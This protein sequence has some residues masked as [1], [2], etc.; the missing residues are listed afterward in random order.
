MHC[1]QTP[2]WGSARVAAR[3]WAQLVDHGIS[4]AQPASAR[5]RTTSVLVVQRKRFSTSKRRPA[6]ADKSAEKPAI[7]RGCVVR[8]AR[9]PTICGAGGRFMLTTPFS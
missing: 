4:S 7:T 6:M 8:V 2:Q 5:R 9:A 3:V 1:E